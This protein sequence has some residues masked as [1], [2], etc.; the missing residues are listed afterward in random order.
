MVTRIVALRRITPAKRASAAKVAQMKIE[1][2]PQMENSVMTV[3]KMLTI[4]AFSLQIER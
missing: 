3:N 4:C 2:R 1:V